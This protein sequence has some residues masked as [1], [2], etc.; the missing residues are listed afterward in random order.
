MAEAATDSTDQKSATTTDDQVSNEELKRLRAAIKN[1]RFKLQPFRKKRLSLIKEFVGHN[2]SQ[3]GSADRVP[4][5]L[6]D[7]AI[8]I[9]LQNLSAKSPKVM[10]V[11]QHQELKPQALLLEMAINHLLPK[12]R[13]SE[14]LRRVVTDGLFSW[15]I[16]KIGLDGGHDSQ[17]MQGFTHDSGQPFVDVIDLDDWFY[18]VNAKRWDQIAFCG[19]RYRVPLDYAQESPL[20]D[21]KI[22]KQLKATHEY[23]NDEEGDRRI[24]TLSAG[25]SGDREVFTKMVELYDVWL[26]R[27]NL[28]LTFSVDQ[29]DLPALRTVP[30]KGPEGG[31][32][33]TLGYGEVPGNIFPKAPAMN[34][35]DLHELYNI[36]F[37]KLGRQAERQKT[38]TGILDGGEKDGERIIKSNDGDMVKM[39]RPDAAREFKWGGPDQ[40]T[41]AFAQM[42]ETIFSRNAGNLDTLGGLSPQAGTLGQEELLSQ[43]SSKNI[44]DLQQRTVEF[45]KAVI[46]H[47]AFY[48]WHDPLIELPLTY[49]HPAGVAIPM[50]FSAADRKGDFWQYDIQIDPYSMQEQTPGAKLAALNQVMS[51]MVMPL[52]QQIAQAGGTIDFQLLMETV[53]KYSNMP[54]LNQ[55]LKFQAPPQTP[56]QPQMSQAPQKG[57]PNQTSHTSVRVNRGGSTASGKSNAMVQTLMGAA[58]PKVA[59]MAGRPVS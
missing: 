33:V 23:V 49:Q 40:T 11:T 39:D 13:F 9:Y 21:E 18:D 29:Q 20:Y 53:S 44:Q 6:L 52:E 7:L 16:V 32:Y 57:Q 10:A 36:V 14:T 47:I 19:N 42:V 51:Q 3:E 25:V 37:R 30:W 26:P 5:N 46:N 48:L 22:R 50:K 17:D 58:Q 4:V 34:W 59:E 12:I 24:E 31:P 56:Q 41:L 38:I 43:G 55:I 1:S 35:L 15:G 54:E 8:S 2:Y 27:K 45:T 28:V